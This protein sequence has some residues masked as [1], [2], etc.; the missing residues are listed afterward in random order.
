MKCDYCTNEI[1]TG[2]EVLSDGRCFCNALHRKWWHEQ[3][4]A[5][6]AQIKPTRVLAK[7]KKR[8][9]KAQWGIIVGVLFTMIGSAV[10]T[11]LGSGLFNSDASIDKQLM[12]IASEFNKSCPIMVD[13]ETRL[14][15][16]V[17]STGKTV[18]YNYT[19]VDLSLEQVKIPQLQDYIRPRAINNVKTS[20]DMK[21][22]RDNKVTMVYRYSDKAGKFLCDIKV[23]PEDVQ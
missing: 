6:Q 8:L 3:G 19:L 7:P 18:I 2:T 16:V 12:Q 13:K 10:G 17:A 1:P 21:M 11:K 23:T 5:T 20:P 4:L 14:N 22:F 9:T 15:N